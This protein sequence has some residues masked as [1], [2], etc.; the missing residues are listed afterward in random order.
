MDLVGFGMD[1]SKDFLFTSPDR[2]QLSQLRASVTG[3]SL[4]GV[5][6]THIKRAKNVNPSSRRATFSEGESR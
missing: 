6:K 5:L 3:V 1:G 2:G 4:T